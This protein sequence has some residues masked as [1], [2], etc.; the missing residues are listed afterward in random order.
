MALSKAIRDKVLGGKIIPQALKDFGL[1]GRG[2]VYIDRDKC[3][4]VI[5]RSSRFL[6]KDADTFLNELSSIGAELGQD[7]AGFILVRRAPICSKARSYLEEHDV[8]IEALD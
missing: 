5:D 3:I 7:M 1:K 6:R 8:S 4:K 2:S